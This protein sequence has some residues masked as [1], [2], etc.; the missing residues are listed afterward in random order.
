MTMVM[1]H[2]RVPIRPP[3]PA[4]RATFSHVGRRAGDGSGVA[5]LVGQRRRRAR[6]MSRLASLFL[7]ASRL[8]KVLRPLATK[9]STLAI[10]FLK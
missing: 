4:L 8:S 7:M 3:H 5:S 10:P 1:W 9:I 2:Q 6:S